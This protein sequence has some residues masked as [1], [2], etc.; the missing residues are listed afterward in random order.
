MEMER[1][2]LNRPPRYPW[3]VT[4][5]SIALM[6]LAVVSYLYL[7]SQLLSW[8]TDKSIQGT[9]SLPINGVAQLG[10]VWVILWLVCV[11]I[12]KA[13][14]TRA[15]AAI[16]LG[17]IFLI[18]V[19]PGVKLFVHRD[20]PRTIV[21]S[22]HVETGHQSPDV[23]IGRG[24]SFPSG[25]TATVF[26][27]VGVLLGFTPLWVA[28]LYVSL[29]GF[30]GL[31]RIFTL[32]HYLSDVAAGAAIG[33][34]SG[35]IAAALIKR[36]VSD[37]FLRQQNRMARWAGGIA[38]VALIILETVIHH[39]SSIWIFLRGYWPAVVMTILGLEISR[40][41]SITFNER[42]PSNQEIIPPP[43]AGKQGQSPQE[44]QD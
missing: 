14:L 42:I 41:T 25:D 2:S 4:I 13:G 5:S 10:K 3:F 33:L 19:V 6:G 43:L 31:L 15:A 12:W 16:L 20:R 39:H 17:L 37:S 11:L 22:N 35:A 1:P 40:T 30:V 34:V 7:D 32:N 24:Y 8:I 28:P 27:V 38:V 23:N 18:P 44:I 21:Q 29:A 9:P 36:H 26:V